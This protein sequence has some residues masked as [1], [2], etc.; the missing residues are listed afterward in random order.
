[1]LNSLKEQSSIYTLK[2]GQNRP[3]NVQFV[4]TRLLVAIFTP[5][6]AQKQQ[7]GKIGADY[8][9]NQTNSAKPQNKKIREYGPFTTQIWPHYVVT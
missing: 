3:F 5:K 6:V 4:V 7:I 1:M 2:M 9:S 8:I